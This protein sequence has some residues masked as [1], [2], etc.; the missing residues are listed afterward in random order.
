MSSS[1]RGL[2]SQAR[3]A[4]ARQE[5]PVDEVCGESNHQRSISTATQLR[6]L[7]AGRGQA[8]L[9]QPHPPHLHFKSKT[10]RFS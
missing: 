2:P 8:E 3:V 1:S 9:P 10:S 6:E 4:A 7:P 5:A